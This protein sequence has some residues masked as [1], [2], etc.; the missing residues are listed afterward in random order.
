MV[1]TVLILRSK[2]YP[3]QGAVHVLEVV[4]HP[5]YSLDLFPCN[6]HIFGS[7]KWAFKGCQFQLDP[8]VQQDVHDFI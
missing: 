3:D 4:E 6:F 2:Q 5:A 8:Q 1:Q 7:L